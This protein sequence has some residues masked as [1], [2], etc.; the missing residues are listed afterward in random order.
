[1]NLSCANC[2]AIY[3]FSGDPP[4]CDTCG[5]VLGDRL[6]VVSDSSGRVHATTPIYEKSSVYYKDPEYKQAFYDQKAAAVLWRDKQ[7]TDHPLRA[8]IEE[9]VLAIVKFIGVALLFTL[10]VLLWQQSEIE[11]WRSHDELT[12]LASGPWINGEYKDCTS[13]NFKGPRILMTCDGVFGV[14]GKVF[15]VR[16]YGLTRFED[17]LES[18]QSNWQCRRNGDTDPAITCE[19]KK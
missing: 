15:K 11:G 19:I 9:G 17:K 4:K 1:M 8:S 2:R 12:T 14:E 3:S 6:R 7:R 5:W 10:G 16:F 13:L 18:F